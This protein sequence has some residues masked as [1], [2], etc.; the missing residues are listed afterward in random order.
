MTGRWAQAHSQQKAKSKRKGIL[1]TTKWMSLDADPDPAEPWDDYS[2]SRTSTTALW[3]E[4]PSWAT[5]GFQTHGS[6]GPTLEALGWL[7]TQQ[8]I[9]DTLL[10]LKFVVYL[11]DKEETVYNQKQKKGCA[12]EGKF[13]ARRSGAENPMLFRDS[14]GDNEKASNVLHENW[15]LN[16]SLN[17]KTDWNHNENIFQKKRKYLPRARIMSWTGMLPRIYIWKI[18]RQLRS[19]IF[20]PF[21]C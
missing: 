10:L 6:H 19:L 15:G 8:E 18:S 2:P 20:S 12:K 16:F 5:P 13:A 11:R 1:P 14:H 17:N 7:V 9:T 3:Q 21:C 4:K